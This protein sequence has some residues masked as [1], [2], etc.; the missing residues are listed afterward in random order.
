MNEDK[1]KIL[2]MIDMNNGFVN[3]GPMANPEYNK[4]VPEQL[5]MIEKFN[6]ENEP[7]DFIME[8]HDKDATEFNKY[9]VH[10]VKGTK[11]CEL[12]P[13][14]KKFE[15]L[16]NVR[17]YHKNS[18]NGMLN[19]RVQDHIRYLKN[20]KEVVIEGVCADLCVMDFA[21]TNARY[22]DELN[23]EAKIFVVKNAIDTF[24]A[25]GHDRLEWM[26]IAQKVME[27]AG[28]EFVNNIEELEEK[29]KEYKLNLK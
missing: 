17:I 23:R 7:I 26:M 28:I 9:P 12:I 11:E 20:L 29:E 27:Q 16:P 14:L 1:R 18:I 2:F 3:F 5:K 21:R 6:R 8:A 22:F 19:P 10:C 4:L 24:D 15:T 13:E 25:P